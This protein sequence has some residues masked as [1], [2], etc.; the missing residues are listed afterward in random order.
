MKTITETMSDTDFIHH[1]EEKKNRKF[2]KYIHSKLSKKNK[3]TKHI[4]KYIK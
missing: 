3:R 2:L 4:K 1:S